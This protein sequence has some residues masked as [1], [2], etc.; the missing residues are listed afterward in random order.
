MRMYRH[1]TARSITSVSKK[2]LREIRSAHEAASNPTSDGTDLS[3]H[4][5]GRYMISGSYSTDQPISADLHP[6][7][8]AR[9][10]MNALLIEDNLVLAKITSRSLQAMHFA[11]VDVAH[12]GDE[13]LRFLSSQTYDLIVVDWMLPKASGLDIVRTIKASKEH[14]STPIIMTTG[15]NDRQDIVMA[16]QSG[17]DAYLVK[18]I[19]PAVLTER[20]GKV[21]AL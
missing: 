6:L 12:D 8:H 21:L 7:A 9:I 4:D 19:S 10:Q 1:E 20:V 11:N 17:V 18:P 15:K 2:F 3:T 5:A 16:L 13:A 14:A